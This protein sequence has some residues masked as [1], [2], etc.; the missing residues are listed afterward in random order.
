MI[1]AA[2]LIRLGQDVVEGCAHIIREARLV[3]G[4]LSRLLR[5]HEL[6]AKDYWPKITLEAPN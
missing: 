4:C 6:K 1:W 2:Q 5:C 3:G